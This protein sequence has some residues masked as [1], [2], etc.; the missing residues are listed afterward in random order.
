MDR[1][2]SSQPEAPRVK[3][4]VSSILDILRNPRARFAAALVAVLAAAPA[5]GGEEEVP[6]PPPICETP[7]R[8]DAPAPRV[9]AQSNNIRL[10]ENRIRIAFDV[11]E[12]DEECRAPFTVHARAMVWRSPEE[13]PLDE[14]PSGDPL[15]SQEQLPGETVVYGPG[16]YFLDAE[17]VPNA[18]R[19]SSFVL[20]VVDAA[21]QEYTTPPFSPLE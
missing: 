20:H 9:T 3:S 6:E 11:P 8:A 15:S 13:V 21:G 17:F 1:I 4:A 14:E 2:P 16:G 12:F 5:C 19:I 18:T 7:E 10:K